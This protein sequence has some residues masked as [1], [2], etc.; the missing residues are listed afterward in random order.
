[1]VDYNFY[2]NDY[3]GSLIPPKAFPEAMQRAAEA[4][5]TFKRRYQVVST[6]D[7]TEKLALCAMAEAVYRA[8]R[9]GNVSAATVGSVTVRYGEDTAQKDLHR[10]LY[11]C[12]SIYLDIYR[13]VSV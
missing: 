4:L 12:A 10:E 1:M 5:Q 9:R 7:D 11:R 3:L 8:G 13:G 2:C 6:G